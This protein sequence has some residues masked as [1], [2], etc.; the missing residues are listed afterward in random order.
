V[1]AKWCTRKAYPGSNA[2][3]VTPREPMFIKIGE[4]LLRIN[5]SNHVKIGGGV[6]E[7]PILEVMPPP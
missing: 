5:R 4:D 3:A 7:N 6:R 2:A 1:L